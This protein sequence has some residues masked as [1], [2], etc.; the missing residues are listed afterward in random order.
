[1][2]RIMRWPGSN[3]CIKLSDIVETGWIVIMFHD[4][5]FSLSHFQTACQTSSGIL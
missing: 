2:K 3:I 4:S 5:R 1:M